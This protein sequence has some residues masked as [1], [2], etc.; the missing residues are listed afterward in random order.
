LNKVVRKLKLSPEQSKNTL[1]RYEQA[2]TKDFFAFFG[3][4]SSTS[5]GHTAIRGDEPAR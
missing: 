5:S 4:E 2:Y 1:N 3:R